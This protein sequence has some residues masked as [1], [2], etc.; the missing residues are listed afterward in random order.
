[1]DG[2]KE[3]GV[4]TL[5]EIRAQADS[6]EAVFPR[7]K[8]KERELAAAADGA[9]EIVFAGCGSAFNVAHAVAPIMQRRLGMTCRPVHSSDVFLNPS[10]FLSPRRNTLAVVISRSGSTTESV[11][12]LRA[13]RGRGCRVVA[14]TCFADSPMAREADVALVLEEAVEKSV[15]TTRS[16][17]SMV[18]CGY[19]LAAAWSGDEDAKRNLWRLPELGRRWMGEFEKTG[20]MLAELEAIGKYAFM[21]SGCCY[22]LAREAQLKIKEMVLLPSDSYVTLDFQHGPMS[23]VD[24]HMLVTILGSDGGR[25]Y[26]AVLAGNMKKLGGRVLVLCDVDD[27]GFRDRSDFLLTLSS[28]LEEG[29]RDILYMPVLQF[30]AYYKSLAT[31]NDPDH[32]NSLSYSVKVPMD[33]FSGEQR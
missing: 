18:L 15:T 14:V 13:V 8:A 21:G 33:P 4:H 9:E 22:G 27:V 20:R 3:K 31:G 7:V 26:D 2:A 32:P 23:N 6:W 5:R 28:G 16:L 11:L 10:M 24:P 19:Y 30:M 25:A 29:Q 12:A 17:T 1:M